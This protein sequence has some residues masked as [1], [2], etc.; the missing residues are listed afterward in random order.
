MKGRPD[1][2]TA[3]RF[4]YE[5][6]KPSE[7]D[8]FSKVRNELLSHRGSLPPG[9][10][11]HLRPSLVTHP[12]LKF[13]DVAEDMACESKGYLE[14]HPDTSSQ[15]RLIRTVESLTLTLI[16]S[17]GSEGVINLLN[18]A[19]SRRQIDSLE[20]ATATAV[21]LD[22]LPTAKALL[23]TYARIQ[24]DEGPELVLRGNGEDSEDFARTY[25]SDV[26]CLAIK[27]CSYE[28]ISLVLEN[29]A[30]VNVDRPEPPHETPLQVACQ[31]GSLRL[32]QLILNPRWELND[33]CGDD[34]TPQYLLAISYAAQCRCSHG[35]TQQCH[36]RMAII[37][38]LIN[39][40][41]IPDIR[42][43]RQHVFA[44]ACTWDCPNIARM[45]L[46]AGA[47]LDARGPQYTSALILAASHGHVELME[48]LLER[49]ATHL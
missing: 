45:M 49:G 34:P 1:L 16:F 10:H 42:T 30:D 23:P 2:V 44:E 18:G 20:W 7:A 11:G 40:R 25:M 38:L 12:E 15:G 8:V 39:R 9:L 4:T 33:A 6:H 3:V 29:K 21:F 43:L 36:E 47:S 41:S 48:Y 35:G 19:G 27:K 14:D 26:L 17:E 24:P 22:D 32:V 46:E 37:S 31:R 5:K 13:G 28:M